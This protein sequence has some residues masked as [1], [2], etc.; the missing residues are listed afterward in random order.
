MHQP[1]VP[2]R[3]SS[4]K[5]ATAQISQF[6]EEVVL[7]YPITTGD[8]PNGAITGSTVIEWKSDSPAA[9]MTTL[10]LG[11]RVNARRSSSRFSIECTIA[12][13]PS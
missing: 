10:G 1:D 9:P 6:K 7:Q 12:F 4:R 3:R 8:T 13:Y 5:T 11:L 2:V